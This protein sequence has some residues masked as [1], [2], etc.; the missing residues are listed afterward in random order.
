VS[1]GESEPWPAAN[2]E[3]GTLFQQ[4]PEILPINWIRLESHSPQEFLKIS[5]PETP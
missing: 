2:E 1:E 4:L 3:V 5:T